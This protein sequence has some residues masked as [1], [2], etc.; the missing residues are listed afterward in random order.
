MLTLNGLLLASASGRTGENAGW[1]VRRACHGGPRGAMVAEVGGW[2]N[3]AARSAA[4]SWLPPSPR[5]VHAAI[6]ALT[7]LLAYVSP[8]FCSQSSRRRDTVP[9][10]QGERVRAGDLGLYVVAMAVGLRG[11]VGDAAAA[12]FGAGISIGALSLSVGGILAFV[13]A[14]VA[15]MLLARAVTAVLDADVFPRTRFPRGVPY[16]V[17]TLVRYGIYGI[18]FLFALGAAGVRLDQVSIMLGG[19]GNRIGLGPQ[20]RGKNFAAGLTL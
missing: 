3:L 9:A 1:R 16:A 8:H 7:G 12:L 13:I 15:A 19:L 14:L 4:G 18:G 2:T 17:A 11:A 10:K 5:C 6:I 20:A